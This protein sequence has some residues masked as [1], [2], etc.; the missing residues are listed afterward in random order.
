MTGMGFIPPAALP[1]RKGQNP[2]CITSLAA[3]PGVTEPDTAAQR[4]ASAPLFHM[5]GSTVWD[6]ASSEHVSR[7]HVEIWRHRR[8]IKR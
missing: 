8:E 2:V 1:I 5:S 6:F 4:P 3:V 7:Q